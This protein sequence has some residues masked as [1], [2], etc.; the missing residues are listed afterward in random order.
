MHS[1]V[2]PVVVLVAV[3]T[4]ASA[5]APEPSPAARGLALRAFEEVAGRGRLDRFDDVYAKG[6]VGHVGAARYDAREKLRRLR[7]WRQAIPDLALVVDELVAQG[8]EVEVSWR[9]RGTYTGAAAG[10]P[11]SGKRVSLSGMS[12]LRVSDGRIV[13]EWQVFN[14]SGLLRQLGLLPGAPPPATPAPAPGNVEAVRR[15]FD[16]G[17]TRGDWVAFEAV[18]SKD[19]VGHVADS[20]FSAG[21]DL[22]SA[23]ELRQR[24]PDLSFAI[25][26]MLVEG[27]RVAVLYTGSATHARSEYGE[28][29]TGKRW[30]ARGL[31]IFRL[32]G[33][34]I[35]EEWG[36]PDLAMIR[37]AAGV[38]AGEPRHL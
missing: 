23:K 21:E 36:M 8:D 29:P 18:H 35:V 15:L 11:A 38:L 4:P 16:D 20:S 30:T 22:A 32:S 6:F 5:A 28:A 10:L 2:L 17:L 25:D 33:G 26:R 24:W 34:K 7:E 3:A 1:R 27:D 9:A 14:E 12:L 37:R 31:V 13:E 19:F